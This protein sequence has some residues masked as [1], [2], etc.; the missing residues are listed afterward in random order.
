MSEHNDPTEVKVVP[1]QEIKGEF[2]AIK[3]DLTKLQQQMNSD[4]EQTGLE[5]EKRADDLQKALTAVEDIAKRHEEIEAKVRGNQFAST[6]GESS[7][8]LKDA[9]EQFQSAAFAEFNGDAEGA[10]RP[11]GSK[12]S[13]KHLVE[14]VFQP[15]A[16]EDDGP[17]N[18]LAPRHKAIEALRA[19]ANR[20]YQVDA[21]MRAQMDQGE[22]EEYRQKGGAR[23]L[24]VYRQFAH[25]VER[26]TKAATELIDT[27]TEV[28]NWIP[29]QYSATLYEKVKIG[30]PLLNL[31]PEIQ[32][33]APTV[34]LP[35]NLNDK[36]AMRVTEVARMASSW[37]V[38]LT[39]G[40][41]VAV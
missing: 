33:A 14:G 19:S 25:Q 29:T 35:L 39:C 12:P 8:E 7:G 6:F 34:V 31:F 17:A 4:R 30:L 22:I 1:L 5:I 26:F 37:A 3:S 21:M 40:G 9:L 16:G 41:T 15:G 36:E 11:A 20:V 18:F 32:M 2:D 10:M 13:V 24:K 23:S 38:P 28:S 27:S